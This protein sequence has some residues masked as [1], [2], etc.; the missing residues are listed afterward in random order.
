MRETEDVF[1]VVGAYP[2][3][4]THGFIATRVYG[5]GAFTLMLN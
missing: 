4:Q 3:V 1:N 5:H 2:Q